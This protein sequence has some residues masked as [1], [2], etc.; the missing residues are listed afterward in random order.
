MCLRGRKY[1]PVR[2]AETL[3]S[4]VDLKQKLDLS[5]RWNGDR[6]FQ[7]GVQCLH[8]TLSP[9]DAGLALS[10]IAEAALAGPAPNQ[11]YTSN[12]IV[13]SLPIP[14]SAGLTTR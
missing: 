4:L 10:N 1:D 9:G 12:V 6:R 13:I 3:Q 14:V 5:R 2:G 7:V 11:P 8:G